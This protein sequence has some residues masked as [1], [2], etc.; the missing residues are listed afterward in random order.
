MWECV[1]L[2]RWGVRSQSVGGDGGPWNEALGWVVRQLREIT[3]S[4]CAAEEASQPA[5][6]AASHLPAC[7][8]LVHFMSNRIPSNQFIV[9]TNF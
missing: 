6:Q 2:S 4:V 1:G 8:V 7:A 9:V 3:R 5:R